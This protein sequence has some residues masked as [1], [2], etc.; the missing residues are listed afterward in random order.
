MLPRTAQLHRASPAI[1]VVLPGPERGWIVLFG[2]HIMSPDHKQFSANGHSIRYLKD[3]AAAL[4][5]ERRCSHHEALNEVARTVGYA[6]WATLMA[7]PANTHRDDFFAESFQRNDR[8]RPEYRAFLEHRDI[9][10]SAEAYR[11]FVVED[12]GH[13]CAL[14]FE[15]Y[16]L[17]RAPGDPKEL[18]ECLH[19][20]TARDGAA[21]LLPQNLSDELLERLL[22][23]TRLAFAHIEH[24][25]TLGLPPTD[26]PAPIFYCIVRI[27]HH[28]RLQQNPRSSG[29]KMKTDD[30][31]QAMEAYHLRLELEF[32]SR[33]TRIQVQQPTLD[34]V[35]DPHG[36]ISISVAPEKAGGTSVEC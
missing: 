6:D 1:D 25:R 35:L 31:G 30:I 24:G 3:R 34:S 33:R 22:G 19:R 10:D 17:D 4:K 12:Y 16:T 14:G 23:H 29:F 11:Q 28:Q 15:K 20:S 5:V 36:D 32:L 26:H 8:A 27:T 2:E 18:A 13:F 7:E 9:K 21:A